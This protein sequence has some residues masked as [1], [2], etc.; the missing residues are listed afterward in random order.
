MILNNPISFFGNGQEIVALMSLREHGNMKATAGMVGV[1]SREL[2]A[3]R[4]LP[5]G[6]KLVLA[7]VGHG[8]R[9]AVANRFSP[10]IVAETDALIT[11][12]ENVYPAVTYADCPSIFF[13]DKKNKIVAIAH[14]GY[15]GTIQKISLNVLE[16]MVASGSII[17]DIEVMIGPAI[18][19]DCYEFGPEAPWVF[20]EYLESVRPLPFGKFSVDLKSIIK[21]QLIE[22]G[23]GE[24]KIF[25]SSACTKENHL[26]FSARREKT[27][28][29]HAGI[30]L[31]GIRSKTKKKAWTFKAWTFNEAR[32]LYPACA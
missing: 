19:E 4:Y 16:K 23:V 25:V 20:R 3:E 5:T 14:S 22:G 13:F 15:K 30:C 17:S 8:A 7:N 21:R 6:A 9:V 32:Q 12:E 2:F 10:E 31:I 11:N 26:L 1:I 29:V 28:P 27:S 18:C 24:N